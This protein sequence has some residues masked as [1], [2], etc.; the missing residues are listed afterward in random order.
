MEDLRARFV[1]EPG[2]KVSLDKIDPSDVE[3]VGTKDEAKE[4]LSIEAER[5]DELQD[6][7]YAERTR[8]LLVVLQGTDTS[9]KDGTV[10]GVFGATSPLGVSVTAFGKP[11]PEELAHDFLWRIHR[12][13]PTRGTIGVFNRSHYEDVLVA[14]VRKLVP[15]R[16]DRAALR[17]DQHV[18]GDPRRL[19]H[20]NSQV[21]AAHLSRRA[22]RAPASPA[23]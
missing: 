7:L 16:T 11:S 4:R 23:R 13:C 9:G 15:A 10:R 19:W 8:A 12:V 14:R 6:R 18:R 2:S 17:A 5:I 3:G 1:V 22:A 20:D 21:H